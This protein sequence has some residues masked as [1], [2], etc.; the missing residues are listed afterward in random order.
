M[1][2]QKILNDDIKRFY[3]KAFLLALRYRGYLAQ[4]FKIYRSQ[5]RTIQTRN[6]MKQQGTQVPPVMIISVTMDF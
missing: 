1:D 2:A 6:M 5:K 4:A 3:K